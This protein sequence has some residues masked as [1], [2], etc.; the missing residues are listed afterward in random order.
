MNKQM[1]LVFENK[2][3]FEDNY[4][5]RTYAH[6]ISRP[7][8]ALTELVANAWDSGAKSVK[9]NISPIKNIHDMQISIEDDGTGMSENEFY[10]RWMTL[11]Y[12]RLKHQGE[13]A[14]MPIEL[15][16]QKRRAYGRNGIGRHSM[17]CFN[18]FYT[19][20]TWKD[21]RLLIFK[22]EQCGGETALRI[23]DKSTGSKEGHGTK[24]YTN[25]IRNF[26]DVGSIQRILSA[27]FMYDPQF[28]MYINDNLIE[29]EDYV[30]IVNEKKIEIEKNLKIRIVAL[31]SQKTARK[32]Q[33]HGIAF[34]VNG[35]LVGEPS[36]L[37]NKKNIADGRTT[38]ARQYTIIVQSKDILSEV[39]SDWT[40]FKDTD[41]V[42][43]VYQEVENFANKLFREMNKEKNEDLKKIIF[44]KYREEI[45]RM[46]YS[47]K[48]EVVELVDQIVEDE[49]ELSKSFL[50]ITIGKLVEI[51]NSKSKKA[52]LERIYS[53]TDN[54]AEILNRILEDWDITDIEYVLDEIDRRL[55]TIEAIQKLSIVEGMDELHVLHPLV[56]EAKWLFGPEYDSSFYISNKRI[57][58]IIKKCIKKEELVETLNNPN[59]RPDI[60]LF[61]DSSLICYGFEDF[62]SK[63]TLME[64]KKL[65][66]IELKCGGKE[67][68]QKEITQTEE[69]MNELYFSNAF[70]SKIEIEAFT[71]G[72]SVSSRMGKTKEIMDNDNIMWGRIVASSYNQLVAT[73]ERRLFGLKQQLYERYESLN[74]GDLL[75]RALEP[76]IGQ[77][78]MGFVEKKA[79]KL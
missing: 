34:W 54:D 33:Q 18:D 14:E 31:S 71:V 41:R 16:D 9:I 24:I 19:V 11:A 72:H 79:S 1:K 20:K 51:N 4:L 27:R 77:I 76:E 40:G 3:K 70:N 49:P 38:I 78:A 46:S 17:L 6:I 53:L 65:L 45:K 2:M 12:N 43:A 29:L 74:T 52:L 59:K 47:A 32:S 67:I 37:L 26:P 21:G 5:S 50:E 28:M 57:S 63:T 58:T 39:K 13:Y 48:R 23:I 8:L 55:A 36:W 15:N 68:T 7:D 66:I 22:L 73:A 56:L 44:K 35:R 42:Q 10:E 30:G 75:N 64:L 69:Y 61:H 62:N 25:I 60:L